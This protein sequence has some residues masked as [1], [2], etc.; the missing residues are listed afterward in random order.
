MSK[1]YYILQ[2]FDKKRNENQ[3]GRRKIKC[4]RE[5]TKPNIVKVTIVHESGLREVVGVLLVPNDTKFCD[6]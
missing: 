1:S 5:D 6:T 4:V 2:I 3:N